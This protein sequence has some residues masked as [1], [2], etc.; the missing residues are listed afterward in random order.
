V[1]ERAAEVAEGT[2]I[3][4][5]CSLMITLILGIGNATIMGWYFL[6]IA[7]CIAA[8]IVLTGGSR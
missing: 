8:Y 7:A 2:A 1:R 6:F 5:I 4:A 3:G